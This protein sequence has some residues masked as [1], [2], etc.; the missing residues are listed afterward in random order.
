MVNAELVVAPVSLRDEL[1]RAQ[2]SR[3]LLWRL[4]ATPMPPAHKPKSSSSNNFMN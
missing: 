1:T 3:D 4:I 2:R